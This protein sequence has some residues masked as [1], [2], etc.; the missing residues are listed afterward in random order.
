MAMQSPFLCA[1]IIAA[2]LA[3]STFAA[4]LLDSTAS[5]SSAGDVALERRNTPVVTPYQ[6]TS[7]MLSL[8]RQ[9]TSCK[10]KLA[11]MHLF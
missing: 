3:A 11:L 6:L 5:S 8:S 4:P 10:S 9:G 1:S 2:L 7:S